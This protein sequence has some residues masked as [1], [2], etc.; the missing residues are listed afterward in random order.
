MEK[1]PNSFG[2]TELLYRRKYVAFYWCDWPDCKCRVRFVDTF[3][4]SCHNLCILC[5]TTS[6]PPVYSSATHYKQHGSNTNCLCLEKGHNKS[7]QSVVTNAIYM[8]QPH[9][10]KS[11]ERRDAFNTGFRLLGSVTLA[12]THLFYIRRSARGARG[13]WRGPSRAA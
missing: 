4:P 9:G 5:S 10:V 12:Q 6:T 13:L 7:N 11:Q 2:V 8:A 1:S 3:C